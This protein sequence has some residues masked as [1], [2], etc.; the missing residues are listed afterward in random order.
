MRQSMIDHPES[1]NKSYWLPAREYSRMGRGYKS[2]H[3]MWAA[4][5]I[6]G[7]GLT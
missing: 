1:G 4:L 7:M 6:F 5:I 2:S 3:G